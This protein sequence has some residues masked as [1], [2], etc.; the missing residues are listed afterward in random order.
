MAKEAGSLAWGSCGRA[1]LLL[2]NRIQ[3]GP[4][5]TRRRDEGRPVLAAERKGHGPVGWAEPAAA[6]GKCPPGSTC[7][8][9]DAH[10]RS[11]EPT[12]GL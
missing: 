10:G 2:S 9:G 11:R 5:W 7:G 12:G 4:A 8:L 1:P 3:K 6:G